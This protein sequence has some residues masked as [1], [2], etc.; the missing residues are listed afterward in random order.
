VIDEVDAALE[1]L[2]RRELGR[3]VEVGFDPPTA[4]WASKTRKR[5]ML[6]VHLFEVR[7][8][9]VMRAG[10]PGAV[11]RLDD[12]A[13]FARR[14]DPRWF[15]LSYWLS[16]W[17]ADAAAEHRTLAAALSA[18]AGYD[19]LP[20]D[21]IEGNL[22]RLGLPV[23]MAVAM[24]PAG[25]AHV[26][27]VWSSLG[28]PLRAALELAV[29]APLDVP[30][31]EQSWKPVLERRLQVGRPRPAPPPG[32]QVPPGLPPTLMPGATPPAAA[33]TPLPGAAAPAAAAEA[34][35]VAAQA[36]ARQPWFE[37]LLIPRD[38]SAPPRVVANGSADPN[39]D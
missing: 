32:R 1:R 7:E 13:S 15:R 38:P 28:V 35:P 23:R 5:P 4:A 8:E 21:A 36:P 16:A 34:P 24:P 9:V 33:P 10:G 39:D 2:L 30:A 26:A 37:V 27:T 20:A 11:E 3:G 29:I 19:A 17:A 22:Q 12:G 18:L 6:D 31:R 14:P 25:D